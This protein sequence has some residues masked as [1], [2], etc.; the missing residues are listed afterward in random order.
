MNAAHLHLLLNHVPVIGSVAALLLLAFGMVRRSEEVTT[1]GLVS[2]VVVA[3]FGAA[4]FFTGRAG[5]E[6]VEHLPGIS[7]QLVH[8]HEEASEI[9]FII[10]GVA[11]A[12]GL[13]TVFLLHARHRLSRA[14]LVITLLLEIGGT[15]MVAYAASLGGQIRHPE[16]RPGFVAP[17]EGGAEAGGRAEDSED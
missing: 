2:V 17:A 8:T 9:A 6:V 12:A 15:G 1:L 16:A 14:L 11:G 4:A 10:L 13:I 5:E 7:R 3:L